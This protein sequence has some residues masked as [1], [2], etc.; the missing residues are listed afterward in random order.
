MEY[1]SISEYARLKGISK[2]A[3]YKRLNSTLSKYLLNV[4]GKKRLSI[5][6]LSDFEKDNIEQVERLIKTKPSKP[7]KQVD[8]LQDELTSVKRENERLTFQVEQL[9]AQ[10][11]ETKRQLQDVYNNYADLTLR[12]SDLTSKMSEITLKTLEQKP[13]FLQRLFLPRNKK[14]EG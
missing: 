10:L 7:S 4:D 5:D 13:S 11:D 12:M 9:T 3:V 2:Q 1:I 14:T 8:A 6:V